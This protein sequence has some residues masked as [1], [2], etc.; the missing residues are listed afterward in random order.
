MLLPWDTAA[1]I[2]VALAVVGV[3]AG[4]LRHRAAMVFGAFA[5]ETALI[6]A[7]YALWQR[8]GDVAVTKVA[9]AFDHARWVWRTERWWHLPSEVSLER[10]ALRHPLVIQ[11]LNGYYAIVHVPALIIFLIW[12]F[13]RHRDTYARW[14]NTGAVLTLLCLLLQSVP[15]APPRML[16]ELG[17]TD[18]A[19]LYGQSVYGRMGSGIAPQLAAMPSVHVGWSV[20][21]ALA[22]VATS[23]S[24]W[25]WVVILHPVLTVLAVVGTA[26]HWWLDGLAAGGLLLVALVVERAVRAAGGRLRRG[27]VGDGPRADRPGRRDGPAGTG[28]GGR[29]DGA[30]RGATTV[31]VGVGRGPAGS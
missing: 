6:L 24:R 1:W 31:T 23:T 3:A 10:L 11:F 28:R 22:V 26:N 21:I 13:V 2:A 30:G 27:R 12:L 25:R 17:F 16:P 14:R 9:G 29:S 4:R 15:V 20:F 5:R 18:A 19:L 8:G 7:L